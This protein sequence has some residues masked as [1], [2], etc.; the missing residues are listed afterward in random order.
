LVQVG[1]RLGF[2]ATAP[3]M[4]R[5]VRDECQVRFCRTPATM[6][7]TDGLTVKI[8]AKSKWTVIV[9]ARAN[10]HGAILP[11]GV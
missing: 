3:P 11:L 7:P 2:L 8:A 5:S 10:E 6:T 4:F 9:P 1:L